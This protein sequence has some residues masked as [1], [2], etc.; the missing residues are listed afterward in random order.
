MTALPPHDSCPSM[1]DL[2]AVMAKLR[3]P[4]G[5]CPWDLVQNFQTI[6]PY[7]IEEAYEVVEAINT[8]DMKSLQEELGDLLMQVVYHTQMASEAGHFTFE[9]VA[10]GITAKMIHRHP[11]VFGEAKAADAKDVEKRIWEDQK[12]KEKGPRESILDDVP[13]ALPALMRGQKLAKRAARVGFEWPEAVHVLDKLEEEIAE[14]RE[15]MASKGRDEIQDELGDM[16][17]C[18]MNFGRMLDLD[19]EETLRKTNAKFERRF[20]GIERDLKAMNKEFSDTN[21][22]EMEALWQAQ[23]RITG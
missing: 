15:A 16:M 5:G 23:K 1:K 2:I 7:T 22:E 21:L 20:R 18:L 12:D 17:F 14:L 3:D 9:D 11:H 19:A 4:N 10:A 13:H 6:A 8:N